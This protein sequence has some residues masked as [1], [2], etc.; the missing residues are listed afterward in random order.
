MGRGEEGM[1][2]KENGRESHPNFHVGQSLNTFAQT[3]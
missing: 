2:S 1:T 3:N